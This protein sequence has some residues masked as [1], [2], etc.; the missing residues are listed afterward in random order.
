MRA[1]VLAAFLVALAAPAHADVGDN[2]KNNLAPV[3]GCKEAPQVIDNP[4]ALHS[5]GARYCR[6][7]GWIL[8]R[9]LAVEP[10]GMATT[11]L[12]K[13]KQED[14]THCYWNALTM[15]NHHGKGYVVL[16]GRLVVV[17]TI[18]GKAATSHPRGYWQILPDGI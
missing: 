2:G 11:D 3:G 7:H 13:C 10:F 1:L 5:P 6:H 16:S 14:S 4:T 8:K 18:N 15:G 12:P 9:H 17:D